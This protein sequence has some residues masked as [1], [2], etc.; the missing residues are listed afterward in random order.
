MKY[1]CLLLSQLRVS[2]I[3]REEGPLG[4]KVS[5]QSADKRVGGGALFE[6]VCDGVLFLFI[7][8]VSCCFDLKFISLMM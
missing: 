4:L 6:C 1:Y 5:D 8:F 7:C 3:N 2:V